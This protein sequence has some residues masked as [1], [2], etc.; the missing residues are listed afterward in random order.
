MLK[1]IA[2]DLGSGTVP[3]KFGDRARSDSARRCQST[4]QHARV[5]SVGHYSSLNS[6]RQALH[7]MQVWPRLVS[8][9]AIDGRS[10]AK[11][12]RSRVGETCG[13]ALVAS[14]RTLIVLRNPPTPR[15][16]L[17]SPLRSAEPKAADLEVAPSFA[18]LCIRHMPESD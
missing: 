10:S 17:N 14:G 18:I 16:P 2:R 5:G 8:P 11:F 6:F 15:T 1:D 7:A 4:S 3:E 12:V 9:S 13:L